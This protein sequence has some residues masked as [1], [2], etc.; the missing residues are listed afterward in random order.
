MRS[1]LGE[2]EALIG[3]KPILYSNI[4]V[5]NT[6]GFIND[7]SQYPLWIAWYVFVS[8]L[9]PVQRL[10]KKFDKFVNDH[11]WKTPRTAT[12]VGLGENVILWQFSHHGDGRFYIYNRH[13]NDPNF[14]DG[15]VNADLN[16][17]IAKRDEFM[18]D[19]F[20]DVHVDITAHY[21]DAL[22]SRDPNQV[23]DLYS[24]LAVHTNADR[25]VNGIDNIRAWYQTFFIDLLPN[26]T[27]QRANF[28]ASGNSRT[29]SWTA[30]ADTGQVLDGNDTF[31]LMND[32]IVFHFTHFHVTQ[33]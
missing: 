18:A 16:I 6:I 29:F 25:S 32:E 7:A 22:N 12:N 3:K 26:G 31:G 1:Y 11:A 17:S 15:M 4:D 2:L 20:G 33:E 5:L 10:Y 30:Q 19:I 8:S 9:W 28:T 21:I 14:P 24:D 23:V 13:T 27:F